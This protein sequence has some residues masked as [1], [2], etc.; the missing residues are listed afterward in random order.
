LKAGVYRGYPWSN[1][2]TV[3]ERVMNPQFST[4]QNAYSPYI[5]TQPALPTH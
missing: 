2:G 4:T 5:T 3:I 1:N